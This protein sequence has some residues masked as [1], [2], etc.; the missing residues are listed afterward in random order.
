MSDEATNA[1]SDVTEVFKF[2]HWARFYFAKEQDGKVFLDVPAEQIESLRNT[3]GHLVGLLD[4]INQKDIDYQT[5][6]RMVGAHVCRILDGA[7]YRPGVVTN[8]LDSREF[9]IEMHLFSLWVTGH[10]AMLDEAVLDFSKW[11]EIFEQWKQ[12]EQVQNFAAS[13]RKSGAKISDGGTTIH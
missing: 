4:E 11:V 8:A 9:Q 6:C 12:S 13:L 5:S 10:E 7:K 1:V 2:E 3:Q